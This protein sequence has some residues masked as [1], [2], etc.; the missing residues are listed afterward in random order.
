MDVPKWEDEVSH[1][2]PSADWGLMLVTLFLG[3]LLP[4]DLEVTA[5]CTAGTLFA[6]TVLS[7][8]AAWPI[9][10]TGLG[11]SVSVVAFH[12]PLLSK[13][14]DPRVLSICGSAAFGAFA[15]S[16]TL[17]GNYYIAGMALVMAG[18]CC[19]QPVDARTAARASLCFSGVLTMYKAAHFA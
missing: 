4:H 3:S 17:I 13:R 8:D 6:A 14:G 1:R 19:G 12:K 2:S 5:F 10:V 18:L 16:N 11:I 9:L 15:L 7:P